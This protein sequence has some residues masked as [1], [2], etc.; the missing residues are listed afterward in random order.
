MT[1]EFAG[2]KTELTVTQPRH[3]FESGSVREG[4]HDFYF[5]GGGK[6]SRHTR[7]DI[8]FDNAAPTATLDPSGVQDPKPGDALT[9]SGIAL[10]GWKVQ[11]AEQQAVQDAQGRFSLPATWP[12]NTRSLAVRLSHPERGTQVYVRR[13][14]SL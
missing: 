2:E 8:Q 14:K 3:T 12:S 4:R 5:T 9:I 1:H 6:V 13:S 11:V 10:P 7:V